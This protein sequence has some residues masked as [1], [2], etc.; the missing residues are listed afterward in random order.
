M[1]S[2]SSE[3][4]G[5][6]HLVLTLVFLISGCTGS[7]VLVDKN[8]TAPAGAQ[9]NVEVN[10]NVPVP[11]AEMEMLAKTLNT[12]LKDQNLYAEDSN[13]VLH[14]TVKKYHF[15]SDATRVLTGNLTGSDAIVSTIVIKHASD[16]EV[17]GKEEVITHNPTVVSKSEDLIRAHSKKIISSLL[18]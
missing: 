11:A 12:G 9:F 14:V 6:R 16:G 10:A 4:V 13:N 2:L 3:M 7:Q 5:L 17:L 15:R 1:K 18:K 8:Y